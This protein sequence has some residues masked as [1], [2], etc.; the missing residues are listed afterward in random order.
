MAETMKQI[1]VTTSW[2]D[3]HKLDLKLAELLR[4]YDIKGTFYIS[5]Q[6]REFPVA[7]RLNEAEVCYLARNFEIGAHTMTHPRLGLLD[8]T[9]ARREIEDSKRTLELITG[10]PV[11]SFCYP[12]GNYSRETQRFVH[13]AGF[14]RART[15][16]RFMT[17]NVD[18][19]ALAT[20]VDTFDHRRDGMLSVI[21]LCG[22]RPW[23]ALTMRRWDRLAKA[24]FLQ[25]AERGEIFHLWGH[26]RDI[27][28]HNDWE[29]LESF[30]AWLRTQGG[31]IFAC[32]ADLPHGG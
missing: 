31:V 29:R 7:E 20:S 10:K 15:V 9:D 30:L 19:F 25:A 14:D 16:Q 1:I 24:L 13:E 26:S 2:D 4:K 22:Y 18:Q 17:R 8:E 11:R 28:A 21:R 3:G 32:N 5:P 12:Y 6:T 23:Q 27:E